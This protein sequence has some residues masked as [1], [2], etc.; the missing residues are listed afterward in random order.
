MDKIHGWSEKQANGGA[1]SALVIEGRGGPRVG[2]AVPR[3]VTGHKVTGCG[4]I[5]IMTTIALFSC[6]FSV[7]ACFWNAAYY[8]PPGWRAAVQLQFQSE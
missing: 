8:P 3:M 7:R 4:V 5:T 2:H 6:L 1:V